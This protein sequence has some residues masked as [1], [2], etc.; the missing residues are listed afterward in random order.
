MS[1]EKYTRI[2]PSTHKAKV[3]QDE[4]TRTVRVDR[5]GCDVFRAYVSWGN[6]QATL[7]REDGDRA[8]KNMLVDSLFN[9]GIEIESVKETNRTCGNR[10]INEHS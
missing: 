1:G 10:R 4:E 5:D 6:V 3:E 9:R 2:P 8:G 7:N